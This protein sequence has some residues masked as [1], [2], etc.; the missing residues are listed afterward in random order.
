MGSV[1]KPVIISGAGVVGL[2]L[3]HALKKVRV[4]A[5]CTLH[6]R[7]GRRDHAAT[8]A[9]HAANNVRWRTRAD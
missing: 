9:T 6:R 5:R 8:S 2:T 3:A 1:V 4:P 7:H